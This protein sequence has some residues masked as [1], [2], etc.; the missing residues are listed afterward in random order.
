MPDADK[1][2]ADARASMPDLTEKEEALIRQAAATG[3]SVFLRCSFSGNSVL[4]IPIDA[5]PFHGME[6]K[7]PAS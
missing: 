2:V 1:M 3:G 6:F 4:G 7:T 5:G